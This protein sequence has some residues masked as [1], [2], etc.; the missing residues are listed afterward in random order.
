MNFHSA[1]LAKDI[2]TQ[3]SPFNFPLK[4]CN[5]TKEALNGTNNEIDNADNEVVL[6]PLIIIELLQVNI[7]LL[8]S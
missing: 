3:K 4:E 8:R 1:K 2:N 7:N 6:N 5:F